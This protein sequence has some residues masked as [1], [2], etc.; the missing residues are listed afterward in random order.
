MDETPLQKKLREL[1]ERQ[2]GGV[3]TASTPDVATDSTPL[4][5]KLAELRNRTAATPET[6]VDTTA[7]QPEHDYYDPA[8]PY[9]QR[10]YWS[11]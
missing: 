4:Q 5:K 3:S 2:Q 6:P 7:E 8:H 10:C 1:R 9:C 11:S